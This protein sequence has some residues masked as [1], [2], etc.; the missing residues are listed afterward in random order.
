MRHA[1]LE[2]LRIHSDREMSRR[3][4]RQGMEVQLRSGS[5]L[6]SQM[7]WGKSAMEGA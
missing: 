2:K 6:E 3:S 5:E 7:K 1:D 4:W